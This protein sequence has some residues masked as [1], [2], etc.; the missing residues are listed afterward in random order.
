[1]FLLFC[2]ERTGKGFSYTVHYHYA[3]YHIILYDFLLVVAII[4]CFFLKSNTAQ[5]MRFSIKDFFSK[6][7]QIRRLLR[8]WSQLLKKSLMVN[9]IFCAVKVS[10]N[11]DKLVESTSK[12]PTE[13]NNNL[14][15]KR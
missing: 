5:K 2:P 13:N 14:K 6:C 1:M 3:F 15:K 12:N 4:T 11:P 7:D 8:I 9:F 10:T